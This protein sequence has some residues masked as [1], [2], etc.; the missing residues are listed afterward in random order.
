MPIFFVSLIQNFFI[1]FGV[2][3]GGSIFAGI[4]AIITD[5]P[6]LRTMID[7]A[8]SIKIWAMAIAL[9][10][11]F[12]SFAIIDKG[13]FEGEI[14]SIIKQIIYIVVALLGANAG[15][16]VMKLIQRCSEIWGK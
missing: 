10:G 3:I 7:I 8:G 15:Y 2:V 1:A 13:L 4:G 12:S 16:S 11:T 14:K 9:G 5:T 6:P